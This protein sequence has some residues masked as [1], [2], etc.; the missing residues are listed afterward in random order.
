MA[1]G[2][3]V[4]VQPGISPTA[5][6]SSTTKP[7]KS[8]PA[9]E[10]VGQHALVGRELDAVPA[11]EGDQHGQHAGVDR[12]RVALG[13]Q[14]DQVAPPG[15]RRRP[16]PCRRACRRRRGN[17]WRSPRSA[18]RDRIARRS[19]RLAGPGPWG[20]HSADDLGLGAVALVA[21]APAHVTRHGHRGAE[22]PVGPG[23]GHFF[24]GRLADAA[25]Q[26]RIARGAEADVV[27][28]D[29]GAQ[30]IVV[31]VHRVDAE[32]RAGSRSGAARRGENASI[33][34]THSTAGPARRRPARNCRRRAPRRADT[35]AGRRA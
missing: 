4:A 1:C 28:E 16:G 8:H 22:G 21:S 23:D 35:C 26:C 12:R 6:Q 9:L 24:G 33:N 31:A 18:G 15:S 27:R 2:Q 14:P 11:G 5:F 29:G 7:S 20:P 34:S 13:V 19:A 10:H 32:D 30:D 3:L 25:D 17:A